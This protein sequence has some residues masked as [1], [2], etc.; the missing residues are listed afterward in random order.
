MEKTRIRAEAPPIF[1]I[2]ALNAQDVRLIKP[3]QDGNKLIFE[4]DKRQKESAFKIM[5]KKNIVYTVLSEK[6]VKTDIKRLFMRFGM[7][8]GVIAG[9]VLIFFY[10]TMLTRIKIVGADRVDEKDITVA[11]GITLPKIF[12]APNLDE[13]ENKLVGLDGIA[14]ASV[15]RK[16]TTLQITV[17]EELPD[18]EIIDTSTPAPLIANEDCVILSVVVV[19]GTAAVKAGDTV[20]KG[21]TLISAYILDAESNQIPVR[22]M[23]EV[24]ATV[25]YQKHAFYADKMISKVRTGEKIVRTVMEVPGLSYKKDCS[26]VS[27]DTETRTILCSNILPFKLIKT[28]YYE[29]R[30]QEIDFHYEIQ[31][32]KLIQDN[33]D[34]LI[35]TLPKDATP[36]K[37]W[38]L[39]K[40]LDKN[41]VLSIYYQIERSVAVRS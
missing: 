11:T 2:N 31:K 22:A 40:I 9:L 13:I 32:D 23:G 20:R 1:V 16:G 24:K 28:T 41:I 4:I 10:S 21:D 36:V 19:Q 18:I 26:F 8:A 39:E 29:T 7:W 33:L 27:Y 15:M 25:Y 38:Y 37:W 5:D 6:G 12:A 14:G 17:I 34:A 3:V 35:A 30:D